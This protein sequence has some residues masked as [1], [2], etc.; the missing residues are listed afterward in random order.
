MKFQTKVEDLINSL[1]QKYI[2]WKLPLFRTQWVRLGFL[3]RPGGKTSLW[4]KEAG[5]VFSKLGNN[6]Q[7]MKVCNE[8]SPHTRANSY[9]S[10]A[11]LNQSQQSQS[12]SNHRKR[13]MSCRHQGL[14]QF[15]ERCLND[16][17]VT[18]GSVGHARDDAAS[19]ASCRSCEGGHNAR[20]E[21]S[22][23]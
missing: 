20:A 19:C 8:K 22:S 18:R 6:T 15:L 17:S 5:E 23:S 21:S 2:L 3:E 4:G 14:G 9:W 11:E 16:T 13:T 1:Q 12:M 10:D 7:V